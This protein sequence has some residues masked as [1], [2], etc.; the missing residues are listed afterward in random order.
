MSYRIK[1]WDKYELHIR[2]TIAAIGHIDLAHAAFDEAV[3]QWPDQRLTLRQGIRV[4]QDH[5]PALEKS[6]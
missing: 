2:W 6:R 3:K 1:L 5:D 4:I